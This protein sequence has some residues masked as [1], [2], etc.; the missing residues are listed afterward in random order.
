[1]IDGRPGSRRADVGG[2]GGRSVVR[3]ESAGLV[4]PLWAV[5]FIWSWGKKRT[6]EAD[7]KQRVAADL[8][9]Q[10]AAVSDI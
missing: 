7:R 10:V 5:L 4:L 3:G 2:L 1:M 6:E 9:L 8:Q